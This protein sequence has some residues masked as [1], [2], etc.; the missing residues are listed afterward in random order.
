VEVPI[1]MAG[2]FST[3]TWTDLSWNNRA[4][5]RKELIWRS[6]YETPA[7]LSDKNYL[8]LFGDII[9]IYGK[10]TDTFGK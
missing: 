6:H 8:P 10:T 4:Y 7:R 2:F 1:P 9:E 5:G 3:D